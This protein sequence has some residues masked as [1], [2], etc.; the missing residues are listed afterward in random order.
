MEMIITEKNYVEKAEN[1]ILKLKEKKDKKN[2]VIPMVTTSK[3]RNLL[4]MTSDIYNEILNFQEEELSEEICGRIDYLKVRF[5]YEAGREEKVRDL[6]EEAKIIDCINEIKG[7]RKRYI[8]FS[9][10]MEALVAYH[11]YYGGRDN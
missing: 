1:V 9:R 4:S 5:L 6:V 8:L 7:N 2:R 10:Y 11:R 3:L